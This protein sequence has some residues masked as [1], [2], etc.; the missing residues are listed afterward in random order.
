VVA[1][2]RKVPLMAARPRQW[3]AR[4]MRE[5]G[6]GWAVLMGGWATRPTGPITQ[7]GKHGGAGKNAFIGRWKTGDYGGSMSFLAHAGSRQAQ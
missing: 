6:G 2:R 5:T 3:E 4:D 1:V 7:Q